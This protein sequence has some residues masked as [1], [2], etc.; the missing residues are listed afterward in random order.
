MKTSGGVYCSSL[1]LSIPR[2]EAAEL[3]KLSIQNGVSH[4]GDELDVRV[5]GEKWSYLEKIKKKNSSFGDSELD[6]K[7]MKSIHAGGIDELDF[8]ILMAL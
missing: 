3:R 2:G 5:A 8:F 6:Q 1:Q 7:E 4:P